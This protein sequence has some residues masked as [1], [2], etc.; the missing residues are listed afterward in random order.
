MSG[1]LHYFDNVDWADIGVAT[2][3]TMVMLSTSLVFTVLVGLPLGNKA[4]QYKNGN[5]TPAWMT[6]EYLEQLVSQV[7]I[8]Q[9]YP[10]LIKR[11]QYLSRGSNEVI[12]CSPGISDGLVGF[13]CYTLFYQV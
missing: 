13:C 12:L 7:D 10:A 2:S 8:G 9:T 11:K 3:D 5:P 6:A 4:V 1:L